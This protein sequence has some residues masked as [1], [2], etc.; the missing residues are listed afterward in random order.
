METG[1]VSSLL[2]F[3]V[4]VSPWLTI[5]VTPGYCMG[6]APVGVAPCVKAVPFS[7][8]YI[9]LLGGKV[10][11]GRAYTVNLCLNIEGKKRNSEKQKQYRIIEILR[12]VIFIAILLKLLYC[13]L[14]MD[15]RHHAP[16][17]LFIIIK[18]IKVRR[19]NKICSGCDAG[20]VKDDVKGLTAT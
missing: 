17:I 7:R 13:R 4:M 12:I 5:I 6:P 16:K 14:N 15:F 3:T 8:T 10:E 1:T 2:R 19:V 18:V 11:G 20:C 9:T